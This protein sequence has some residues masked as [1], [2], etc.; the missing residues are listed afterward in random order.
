MAIYFSKV[1]K[2]PGTMKKTA[3]KDAK[4]KPIP[5]MQVTNFVDKHH[6]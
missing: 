4:R 5:H 3:H 6:L 2:K 1:E